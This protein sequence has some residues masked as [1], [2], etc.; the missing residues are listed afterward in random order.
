VTVDFAHFLMAVLAARIGTVIFAV[1]I[2]AV[3]VMVVFAATI[4][5]AIVTVVFAATIEAAIVIA[6]FVA[7]IRKREMKSA[8]RIGLLMRLD[9][10]VRTKCA[11][12]LDPFADWIQ[13]K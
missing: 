9:G 5:A 13:A 3:I 10:G 6:V 12:D 1:R 2:G 7:M 4:E 8:S 11:A